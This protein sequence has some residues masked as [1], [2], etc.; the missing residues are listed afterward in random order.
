MNEQYLGWSVFDRVF[1]DLTT[2]KQIYGIS[3]PRLDW[4][5]L[6]LAV[7]N[8]IVRVSTASW[9]PIPQTQQ[10]S[11]ADQTSSLFALKSMRNYVTNGS[12]SQINFSNGGGFDTSDTAW[13]GQGGGCCATLA[14]I[15]IPLTTE[16]TC[17][18]GGYWGNDRTYFGF[19][20]ASEIILLKPNVRWTL[21]PQSQPP[22]PCLVQRDV[23]T[24]QESNAPSGLPGSMSGPWTISGSALYV[25]ISVPNCTTACFLALSVQ[26]STGGAGDPGT[27]TQAV[28]TVAQTVRLTVG[29]APGI[30]GAFTGRWTLLNL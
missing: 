2:G 14:P 28:N 27:I 29:S 10:Y 11:I 13:N 16:S 5:R 19:G 4:V 25:D 9:P 20:Y 21:A 22:F 30:G 15:V 23:Y 3:L 1:Y 24:G 6:R 8:R 12:A 17:F 26:P 18:D 7:T